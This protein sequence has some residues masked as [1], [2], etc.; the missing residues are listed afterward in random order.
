[1]AEEIERKFLTRNSSWRLSARGILCRQGYITRSAR[2]L[3]RVR[4]IG[5]KGYLAVKSMKDTLARYE[6]EY[7]IPRVDAD[8]MLDLICMKP[9]I[10]KTRYKVHYKGATWEIDDFMG[11]NDG[12]IVAEVELKTKDQ[13]IDLPPWTGVEVTLEPRFYNFNLVRHPFSRW[14]DRSV[15][16]Q[17]R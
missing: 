10:E 1:M 7:P 4:V 6:F 5:G 9:L 14:P 8:E 16:T 3:V 15:L 13:K 11:A 12:L 2:R 17:G